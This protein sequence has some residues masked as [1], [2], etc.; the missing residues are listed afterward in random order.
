M[1][2]VLQK[3]CTGSNDV[4]EHLGGMSPVDLE[5][6]NRS[7]D[8]P[9]KPGGSSRLVNRC[10]IF[11][12]FF[13]NV[14][15]AAFRFDTERLVPN[16]VAGIDSRGGVMPGPGYYWIGREEEEEVL[17][18]LRAKWLMR[19]GNESDPNFKAKVVT[20]EREVAHRFGASYSLAVTSGTA[21]LIVAL[22]SLGV[23]PGDEVIV[24]GYTYIASISSVIAV[25]AVPVLA[26]IDESLNI[27]PSDIEERITSKT[28]AIIAVHM[29]GNPA[30][31]DE[32]RAIADTHSLYLVEDT[33]QAFGGR[34]RGRYLGTFGDVGTYSFN[35]FKVIN[36]GD[37]G[38]IVFKDESTFKTAFAYHDQGHLPLRMGLEVGKRSVIG[39]NYRMNELTGAVV[40]AQFRKID[41][42]LEDLRRIKRSLKAQIAEVPGVRFRSITDAD[43]ECHTLLTLLLPSSETARA[44]AAELGTKTISES[45]WHVYKNIEQLVN[46]R[47]ITPGP[48][49]QSTEFP[50]TVEYYPGMLPRTDD[51]LERAINISIG[52]VDAGLGA[53]FGVHP[54]ATEDE[55]ER[56][57]N[58]VNSVLRAHIS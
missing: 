27:D 44:I 48:P 3:A 5:K 42:V 28:K 30:Q 49:F 26:E 12:F 56:V 1:V 51:I 31:I 47:Q 39:V 2:L 23:G 13:N 24:P 17:D 15:S 11:G 45:G 22:T 43:G 10:R 16:T 46:K 20:L 38:L 35:V 34:Y 7:A 4:L 41:A 53:G 54:Q 29:L 57:A 25:G 14:G 8:V 52:V 33:A 9:T 36:A 37:G 18:V 21:A 32:I 6:R 55:I 40:L 19:Y 50:T 58:R